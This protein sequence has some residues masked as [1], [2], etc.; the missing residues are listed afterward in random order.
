MVHCGNETR[1]KGL[2]MGL[3]GETDFLKIKYV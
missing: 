3:K 2:K 1:F